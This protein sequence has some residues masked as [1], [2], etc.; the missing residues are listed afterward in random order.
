MGKRGNLRICLKCRQRRYESQFPMD[1]RWPRRI[2][3]CAS[4]TEI[5]TTHK[6]IISKEAYERR[7]LKKYG[8]SEE[9][10]EY[11][12]ESQGKTCAICKEGGKPLVIDHNHITGKVRGLLCR[13][14]NIGLGFF[15]DS[16]YS[17]EWAVSYLLQDNG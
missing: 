4:C 2:L 16:I 11:F 17:L 3:P 1:K 8:I 12:L 14:C 7:K 10:Y 5:K 6:V 13:D 9:D 15:K